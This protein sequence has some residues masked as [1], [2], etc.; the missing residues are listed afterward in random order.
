MSRSFVLAMIPSLIRCCRLL[1]TSSSATL[2]HPPSPPL[3]SA[4]IVLA[5][6]LVCHCLL[7]ATAITTSPLL[8]CVT[9]LLDNTTKPLP[10]ICCQSCCRVTSCSQPS[11]LLVCHICTLLWLIAKLSCVSHRHQTIPFCLLPKL[12]LG[13]LSSA[14]IVSLLALP[15]VPSFNAPPPS[16]LIALR[17]QQ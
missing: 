7:S 12:S 3:W 9:R 1:L 17:L 4:A 13:R 11:S 8:P 6:A 2:S 16:S 14:V 10:L 5:S 15:A